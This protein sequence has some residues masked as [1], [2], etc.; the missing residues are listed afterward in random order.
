M[1]FELRVFATVVEKGNFSEAAACL[2]LTPSAISKLIT[3]LES[4]LGAR[5]LNRTTRRLVLTAEGES[6]YLRVRD[7]L[8]AIEDAEAEVSRFGQTPRGRLRINSMTGFAFHQLTRV[9]PKFTGQYPEISV[10]LA[11]TDRI[12]DLLAENADIGIR[13]GRMED[14]SLVARKIADFERGLYAASIYLEKHGMPNK[15]EDLLNHECIVRTGKPPYLWP[16][17][18]N[19]KVAELAV[20]GRIAVD[21]AETA[22]QIA[23]AGGGITWVADM[24]VVDAV[25]SGQLIPVLPEFHASAPISLSAVYPHGKHRMPKVRAFIDFLITEFSKPLWSGLHRHY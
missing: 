19:G 20:N 3:R 9:L 2:N 11:V 15:P 5:L 1:S 6:F 22:L 10:E 7:I 4:R 17:L 16:F 23:I 18:I 8:S 13:S 12:V 14:T 21:N 25:R 24:L